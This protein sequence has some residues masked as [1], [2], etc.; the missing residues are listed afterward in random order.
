MQIRI[1]GAIVPRRGLMSNPPILFQV[2]YSTSMVAVWLHGH[3]NF[4]LESLFRSE[5]RWSSASFMGMPIQ[6]PWTG[7]GS[8]E[9]QKD[10]SNASRIQIFS[11]FECLFSL[12][13]QD[14]FIALSSSWSWDERNATSCQADFLLSWLRGTVVCIKRAIVRLQVFFDVM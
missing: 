9:K 1:D 5:V 14:V 13:A 4:C 7:S 11:Q 10:E 3:F 6:E 12:F 8:H 2:I